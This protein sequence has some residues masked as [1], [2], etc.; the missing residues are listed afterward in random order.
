MSEPGSVTRILFAL[1]DGDPLALQA[2]WQRYYRRLLSVARDKLRTSA[3]PI[4]DE[5]DVAQCAFLS[6][7]QGMQAGRFPQLNDREN[8]WKWLCVI[9]ARTAAAQI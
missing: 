6:F 3:S 1:Q 8:L 4:A 2:I 5:E 9:T 7:Y